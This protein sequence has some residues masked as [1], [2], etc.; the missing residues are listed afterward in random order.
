MPL[1]FW[2]TNL[3]QPSVEV[4]WIGLLDFVKPSYNYWL[5]IDN[6]GN[7]ERE[8]DGNEFILKFEG[9]W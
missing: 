2:V 3:L 5:F 4:H 1:F 8:G 7:K 9:V 6:S